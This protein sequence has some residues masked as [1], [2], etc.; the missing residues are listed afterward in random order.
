MRIG[1]RRILALDD[2]DLA[3][4]PLR[5]SLSVDAQKL[6]SLR[7]NGATEWLSKPERYLLV[8]DGKQFI[9]CATNEQMLEEATPLVA[10]ALGASARFEPPRA[11]DGAH[12]RP[13]MF[14][15]IRVPRECAEQV[16]EELL[17]RGA[18][19]VEEDVQGDRIVVRA[20]AR[21]ADLIGYTKFLREATNERAEL[22]SWLVRYEA[23]T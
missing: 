16:R 13:V 17:R 7:E 18:R 15:R 8:D 12:L 20:E 23:E 19:V 11:H 3:A 2:H 6:A 21:L 4:Y 14:V 1:T 22:W 5:Q 10:A 9:L